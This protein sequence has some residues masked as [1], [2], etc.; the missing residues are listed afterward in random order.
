MG[1]KFTSGSKLHPQGQTRVVKN[2]PL[3]N[4]KLQ[5][6]ASNEKWW[7]GPTT[8]LFASLSQWIISMQHCN[9]NQMHSGKIVGPLFVQRASYV[10]TSHSLLLCF[11]NLQHRLQ[12]N[13]FTLKSFQ[14]R[15]CH[16]GLLCRNKIILYYNFAA[17]TTLTVKYNSYNGLL[18]TRNSAPKLVIT[19]YLHA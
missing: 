16:N 11:L 10:A 9:H 4:S 3:V 17:N 19:M 12:Q 5:T 1:S 7:S 6:R 18:R 15:K 8:F 2:R 14:G 13:R